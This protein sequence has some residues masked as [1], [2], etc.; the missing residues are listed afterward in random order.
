MSCAPLNYAEDFQLDEPILLDNQDNIY[1]NKEDILTEITS[2]SRSGRI[3]DKI[4]D[5]EN[6]YV[7]LRLTLHIFYYTTVDEDGEIKLHIYSPVTMDEII[8]DIEF[9]EQVYDKINLKFKIT[10]VSAIMTEIDVDDDESFSYELARRVIFND[11][12]DNSVFLQD[13]VK[14]QDSI[15]VFYALSIWDGVSGLS[16]F[17]WMNNPYGIQVVRSSA[18][19][20]V[21]A[22]EIGHYFGLYHTFQDPTDHVE[23]TPYKKLTMDKVGTSEDPN[24]HNIMSY[25]DFG[26]ND[27]FL[28]NEQIA[29]VEAFLTT[30]RNSHVML[31]EDEDFSL[32]GL[33]SSNE[34]REDF[35][36]ACR[37]MLIEQLVQAKRSEAKTDEVNVENEE[38][39]DVEFSPILDEKCKKCCQH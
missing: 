23:D 26:V 1:E 17:P 39:L 10:S 14:N 36:I 34:E 11:Y 12:R 5:C 2:S 25:P 19:K 22:H 29:R 15:S 33:V 8:E 38:N 9:A 37:D 20:Y 16:V 3:F 4:Y 27:L 6:I 13:A 21:F 18:R 30:S 35:L 24:Q 7:R 28:T 32:L 31:E